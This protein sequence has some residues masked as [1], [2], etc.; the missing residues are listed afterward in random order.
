MSD[1]LSKLTS[2]I[3]LLSL[4]LASFSWIKLFEDKDY[5]W[6]RLYVHFKETKRGHEALLGFVSLLKWLVIAFYA[7]TIFSSNLDGLYHVIVL[8]FYFFVLI[9][10][11]ARA[12]DKDLDFPSFSINNI[13][14]FVFAFSV[15]L[16]L[17]GIAPLDMYLWILILDKLLIFFIF[18][19]SFILGIFFDFRNDAA[20]NRA[21]SKIQKHPNLLSIAII[22]SYGRGST[23]EFLS[24]ILSIKYNVLETDTAFNNSLGIAKAVNSALTAKKQIFVAEIEDYKRGDIQEMMGI[25]NP[26]IV[27]ICGINQQKVSYF[28]GMNEV[29]SSKYEAIEYLNRD[30]IVLFNGNNDY[31][32][33]LYDKTN[34]KKFKYLTGEENQGDVIASNIREGKFNLSFDVKIFGKTYKLSN[35]KLLG[36]QNIENLLPAI[37]IGAYVGI[38]FASVR[39]ALV[40]LKPLVGTMEPKIKKNGVILIDD[41]HNANIN[42]VLRA[43]SY[44]APYKRKKVLVLEP[45]VELGK[46]ASSELEKIGF[47]IGKTFDFVFLTND[48]YFESIARGITKA[49]SSCKFSIASPAGIAKFVNSDCSREDVVIFEGKQ[50]AK[51]L[52]LITAD[53][54]Y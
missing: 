36:M 24:K 4:A 44:A 20:I 23:K 19:F 26:K 12:K 13:L 45:L 40:T 30:G 3:F 34:K 33:L 41:T 18:F 54:I 7:I 11:I 52:S 16:I 42:S 29:L 31:A 9:K 38:D 15:E 6:D 2:L 14:I 35:I 8:A 47:E 27:I 51:S 49:A 37:F 50:A 1:I 21:I 28:G 10:F 17:F 43:T 5:R 53:K 48:N 22:G 25:I 32:N 46:S 39:R